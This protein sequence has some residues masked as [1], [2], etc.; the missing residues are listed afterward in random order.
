MSSSNENNN[1]VVEQTQPQP[2]ESQNQPLRRIGRVE[3]WLRKGYGFITDIGAVTQTD[4]SYGW[5]K[6]TISNCKVFVYHNALVSQSEQI[7]HRL[8]AH[9]LV[10]YTIDTSKATR[11]NRFQAFNVTGLQ[12]GLLLCDLNS[13][14]NDDQEDEPVVQR[15]RAPNNNNN[16]RPVQRGQQQHQQQRGQQQPAAFVPP[17]GATVVYYVPQQGPI[18]PPPQAAEPSYLMPM[19]GIP[20]PK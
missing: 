20:T 17:A 3:R 11:D 4:N 10:E 16:R 14:N 5:T 1:N 8:Y 13:N 12:G 15:S 2:Q 18:Q 9:E 7:F 19:S 6:D